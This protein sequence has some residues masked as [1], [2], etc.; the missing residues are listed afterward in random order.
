MHKQNPSR[1]GQAQEPALVPG[2]PTL[3]KNDHVEVRSARG[4]VVAGTIDMVTADGSVFW[5]IREDG[6][7]RTMLCLGDDIAVIKVTKDKAG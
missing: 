6:A 1:W 2:W 3:C 7:G 4:E 5:M